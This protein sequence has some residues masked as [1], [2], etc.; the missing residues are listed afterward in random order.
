M[1]CLK[2]FK[3]EK[4]G[5]WLPVCPTDC[6][7]MLPVYQCSKCGELTS[8]YDPDPI[9]L[10]CESYNTVAVNKLECIPIFDK[11]F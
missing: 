1:K 4:K 7:T 6:M 10:K 8:G 2:R 5:E 3:L 9:C 11:S